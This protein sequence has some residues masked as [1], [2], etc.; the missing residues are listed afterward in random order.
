MSSTAG[1]VFWIRLSLATLL[2]LVLLLAV[3]APEPEVRLTLL[4]ALAAGVAAGVAVYL[5][6]VWRRPFLPSALATTGILAL[7]AANEEV[8]WRRFVLGEFLRTGAF[9]ALA[10]STLGFALAHRARP[11]LHLATGL[12]FG[13]LYLLTG[14]LASCVAAHWTYNVCLLSM[15][16][17]M[18]WRRGL[19]P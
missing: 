7:T 6:V 16:E 10:G 14:A 9:A 5:A 17:R 4:A 15:R 13:A 1:R 11:G 12:V 3:S 8:L 19:S 2:S 18:G